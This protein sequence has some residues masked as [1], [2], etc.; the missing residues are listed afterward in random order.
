METSF[1]LTDGAKYGISEKITDRCEYNQVN[2]DENMPCFF[3]FVDTNGDKK[4]NKITLSEKSY[5][6]INTYYAYADRF[7]MQPGEIEYT[8]GENS[9]D[10][11]GN[12][13]TGNDNAGGNDNTGGNNNTGENDNTGNDN[14]NNPPMTRCLQKRSY[15]DCVKFC[16]KNGYHSNLCK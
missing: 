11:T 3:V 12:D 1:Y 9:G 10:N 16:K 4:P 5:K 6:D 7:V 8:D 2:R 14:N 13:N 15:D